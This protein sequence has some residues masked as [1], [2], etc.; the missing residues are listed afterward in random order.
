M[1]A[2]LSIEE[3]QS[4]WNGQFWLHIDNPLRELT[5][6]KICQIKASYD[7]EITALETEQGVW[8]EELIYYVVARKT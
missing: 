8:Y 3:A 5:P 6:P 7:E 1:G 4:R 2:Y